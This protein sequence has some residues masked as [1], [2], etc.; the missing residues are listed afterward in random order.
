M[1]MDSEELKDLQDPESWDFENPIEVPANKKSRAVVSVAFGRDDFE[2]VV[3]TARREGK[4][5][6]EFIRDA[7]LAMARAPGARAIFFA[8]S[9]GLGSVVYAGEAA[10]ATRSTIVVSSEE[11]L[12]EEQIK[13]A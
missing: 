8:A 4:R 3:T 2:R 6:S 10:S 7:A 9:G 1:L 12:K 5:T 11:I 13:V